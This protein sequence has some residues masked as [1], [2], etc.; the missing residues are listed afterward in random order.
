LGPNQVGLPGGLGLL[1]PNPVGLA[2][3]LGLLGPNPVGHWFGLGLL[4]PKPKLDSDSLA[5]RSDSGL[6]PDLVCC[7]EQ[8]SKPRRKQSSQPRRKQS[9]KPG[10]SGSQW[11]SKQWRFWKPRSNL[12]GATRGD[13]EGAS[14]AAGRELNRRATVCGMWHDPQTANRYVH[15]N[16]AAHAARPGDV[17]GLVSCFPCFGWKHRVG[18]GGS[19]GGCELSGG[20]GGGGR[21]PAAAAARCAIRG[22]RGGDI[23]YW[24][25]AV[26]PLGPV[27]SWTGL[28][29]GCGPACLAA[30]QFAPAAL[31]LR[32]GG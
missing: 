15:L 4:G 1:G 17:M 24:P 25:P 10:G 12:E 28:W 20:V 31:G 14:T 8:S 2:S 9:S 23:G 30:G 5:L 18:R 19:G 26:R 7:L 27:R 29:A 32:G 22:A 16:F 3:G 11:A 21:W 6:D 13:G